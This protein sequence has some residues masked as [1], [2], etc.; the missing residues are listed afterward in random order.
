MVWNRTQDEE[1]TARVMNL[2]CKS[3]QAPLRLSTKR[4]SVRQRFLN[5]YG[6]P[7]ARLGRAQSVYDT[8]KRSRT[9]LIKILGLLF[10]NAPAVHLRGLE[11]I[12]VD[13]V[14]HLHPW[15]AFIGKLQNEWQDF[16]LYVRTRRRYDVRS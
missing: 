9:P 1:Y 6:Q 15:T 4:A 11:T 12:W 3:L 10:W 14:I 7:Y 13:S 16:V 8:K 2:F 5:M